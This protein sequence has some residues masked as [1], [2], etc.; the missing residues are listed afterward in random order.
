MDGTAITINS[1]GTTA[2]T[3]RRSF[4]TEP[5]REYTLNVTGAN[6]PVSFSVGTTSGGADLYPLTLL[7]V[8]IAGLPSGWTTVSGPGTVTPNDTNGTIALAAAGGTAT[9]VRCSYPVITGRNYRFRWTTSGVTCIATFG[10]TSGGGEYKGTGTAHDPLGDNSLIFKT[11]TTTLWV[12][13]QRTEA[14]TS[15]IS[16]LSLEQL[17]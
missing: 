1:A 15:T 5:G 14:G 2:T 7:L 9:N 8:N 11:T 4:V 12:M 3:A 13:F 10:T 17:D 16:S 6:A